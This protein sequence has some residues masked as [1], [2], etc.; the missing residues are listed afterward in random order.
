MLFVSIPLFRGEALH[1]PFLFCY[2]FLR[3]S[4]PNHG[5]QIPKGDGPD[6]DDHEVPVGVGVDD[7]SGGAGFHRDGAGFGLLILGQLVFQHDVL[8]FQLGHLV[9][10]SADPVVEFRDLG[11]QGGLFILEAGDEIVLLDEFGVVTPR[12]IHCTSV[13]GAVKAAEELGDAIQMY[14][15]LLGASDADGVTATVRLAT[16]VKAQGLR[17]ALRQK[18]SYVLALKVFKSGGTYYKKKSFWNVLRPWHIPVFLSGGVVC[19]FALLNGE[20]KVLASGSLPRHSPFV[21]LSDLGRP[22]ETGD[23]PWYEEEEEEDE[24]D[25]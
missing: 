20:G 4:I 5:K 19:G 7:G 22:G 13:E 6:V 3:F 24:F 1:Q 18:E 23:K 17:E 11:F 10:E 14:D 16:L 8:L 25:F 12:G 21:S 2:N 15:A 9:F